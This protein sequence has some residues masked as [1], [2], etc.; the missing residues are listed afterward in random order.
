M[1][2]TEPAGQLLR[3]HRSDT[4][5]TGANLARIRR[6]KAE[7]FDRPGHITKIYRGRD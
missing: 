5:G 7:A 3:H 2:L 1:T 6:L 4:A